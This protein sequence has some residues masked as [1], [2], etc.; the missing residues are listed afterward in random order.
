MRNFWIICTVVLG[1]VACW[2]LASIITVSAGCSVTNLVPLEDASQCPGYVRASFGRKNTSL[3][4]ELTSLQVARWKA[5]VA[6]DVATELL[7]V[8]LPIYLIWGIQMSN[9]LKFRVVLAF[10]FRIP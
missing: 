7:F 3:M 6:L 10:S 2:G 1:F 4:V 8:L 5:V 9:N